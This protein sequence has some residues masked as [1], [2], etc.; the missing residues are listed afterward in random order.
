MYNRVGSPDIG[1]LPFE[2]L[3]RCKM[4]CKAP[5][6]M[7]HLKKGREPMKIMGNPIVTE[8]AREYNDKPVKYAHH[9][10]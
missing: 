1:R 8:T 3:S 7:G 6:M 10:K 5:L 9:R 4:T 2:I